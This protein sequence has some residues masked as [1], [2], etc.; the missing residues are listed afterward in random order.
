MIRDNKVFRFGTRDE[1]GRFVYIG[2]PK[3]NRGV[4]VV[5][6]VNNVIRGAGKESDIGLDY[7]VGDGEGLRIVSANNNVQDVATPRIVGEG[8]T[9]V[10][11]Y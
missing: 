3:V 5:N 7:Q 9:L 6:V 2:I 11:P 4:G 10:D 1:T 8:V